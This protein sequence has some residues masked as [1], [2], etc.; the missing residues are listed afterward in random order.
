M[1]PKPLPPSKLFQV[2]AAYER[3]D[4]TAALRIA[5]KFP[6]LGGQKTAIER[7]WMAVTRPDFVREIGRDPAADVAAGAA[8]LA[9]RYGFE[10]PKTGG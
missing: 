7:G 2:R 10:P 1:K 5:A 8:A 4:Y 9:E 3:G 6:Q